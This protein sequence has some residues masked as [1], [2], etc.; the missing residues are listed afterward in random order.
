MNV[1]LLLRPRSKKR[2]L[3]LSVSALILWF[4][5]QP[6]IT[7]APLSPVEYLTRPSIYSQMLDHLQKPLCPRFRK[8][9]RQKLLLLEPNDCTPLESKHPDFSADICFSP[10]TCNEGLVRVRRRD[11]ASCIAANQLYPVSGNATHDAFHRQFSGPDSFHVVFSGSEKL[12]PPDWYHAGQCLYVFPFHI[13]NPGKLSLDITHLYDS[14]GAVAEQKDEW[15][16][17]KNQ[18]IIS[19]QPLEVCRGC[20]TRVAP[21]RFPTLQDASSGIRRYEGSGDGIVNA[22]GFLAGSASSLR[23][24]YESYNLERVGVGLGGGGSS[25]NGQSVVLTPDPDLPLCSRELAVQGAWLP[26]HPLDRQSWRQS[27]YTWIPLGCRYD[28]PLD[29]TCLQRK[30]K[31]Q[32]ILFQGDTHLREAMTSLLNR[33]NGTDFRQASVYDLQSHTFKSK[34]APPVFNTSDIIQNISY[35]VTP[36]VERLERTIGQTTLTYLHDPLFAHSSEKSDMLVANMGHWA[37]GT[38]FLDQQWTTSKYHDKLRDLVEMIQQRARD[39]QDLEDEDEDFSSTHQFV[40]GGG[41]SGVGEDGYEEEDDED[42]HGEEDDEF[43][44]DRAKE[45]VRMRQQQ[46]QQQGVDQ[47]EG[48]DRAEEEEEGDE[49]EQVD[50]DE[51]EMDRGREENQDDRDGNDEDNG[52]RYGRY[53]EEM[54][55]DLY[56]GSKNRYRYGNNSNSK[57]RY[58]QGYGDNEGLAVPGVDSPRI[59]FPDSHIFRQSKRL[60]DHRGAGDKLETAG[61][62]LDSDQSDDEQSAPRSTGSSSKDAR[63]EQG[64]RDNGSLRATESGQRRDSSKRVPIESRLAREQ[65]GD[66][67][68]LRRTRQSGIS[69]KHNNNSGSSSSGSNRNRS[70]VDKKNDNDNVSQRSGSSRRVV[71]GTRTNGKNQENNSL[72]EKT[73]Y[74]RTR[75]SLRR[76]VKRKEMMPAKEANL[77]MAWMGMVAYPESIPTKDWLSAHDWRTIYRLRYWN[78]IAEDVMLLHNVR[79]MDFFSMTLSMLDTSPDRGHFFGTDAAEAM[80][81]EL[82][83]KLGLCEDEEEG[84]GIIEAK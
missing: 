80:I 3:I 65:W 83:F 31:A 50:L 84:D 12:S 78:Q 19:N 60:K 18:K 24:R 72:S 25:S 5:I 44:L 59:R 54:E 33:L 63:T 10:Y 61:S 71:G 28:K 22:A 45:A 20:Q 53:K 48:E 4:Y 11:R 36:S 40:E 41:Y 76:V 73:G 29:V 52:G 51:K 15:P 42:A 62:Y 35:I 66:K 9:D 47:Q 67:T 77:K 8:Y 26:A 75:R 58:G 69:N 64:Y 49:G 68:R 27:N 1:S 43:D 55:Q 70:S 37:T 14:F 13:S 79:F 39:L 57:H 74:R 16:T 17:L 81:E 82:Q 7:T 38:K 6:H 34:P 56:E 32:K 30:K 21:P 46:Q 2:C 23:N